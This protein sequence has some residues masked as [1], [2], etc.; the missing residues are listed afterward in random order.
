MN[1]KLAFDFLFSLMTMNFLFSLLLA[2][3][4]VR[5]KDLIHF[6][7]Y[8]D[9]ELFLLHEVPLHAFK[10]INMQAIGLRLAAHT[11]PPLR[12]KLP[13]KAPQHFHCKVPDRRILHT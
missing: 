9:L 13:L 10:L 12:L 6:R 7:C 4:Q 3:L 11:H 8:I 2:W 5:I 1:I